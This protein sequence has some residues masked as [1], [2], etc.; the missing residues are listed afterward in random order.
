MALPVPNLDDRRFQDLVDEAK[1]LVQ[2]RCPEWTDHN[3]SDP[4]VTL[5]E[6][7]AW[8]TDQVVYRLNRVPDRNYV[9]FLELIGVSLYPPT[10]ARTS[11]TFWLSAPQP[12][13]VTIAAGTQAATVR[14]DTSEAIAFTSIEDLP[15]VPSSLERLGSMIDGKTLRD[16]SAALEKGTE[17][18]CFQPV[19]KA[20][21][22]L[23][24][25]LSEAVP[26]NAVRLRFRADIEG[27]GVDPTNPPLAWEAWTGDDWEPCELDSDTTGGLNRD[28][29]VVIHVP[30]GHVVSLIAKQRGGW[31][32]AR[33]TQPVEGQ[34][35]YS[36]SPNIKGLTAITIGGTV[37]AVNAELVYGEEVGISD[38]VPGQRFPVKRGPIVPGD[39]A[40]ILEVTGAEGWDEWTHVGDFAASGPDDRHFVL[41]LSSGEVRLGPAVRLADGA[42]RRYGAVPPK[43]AHLRLREYRVGG[44]RRGNVATR[45]ISVMKSSIPFVARVENRRPARGGVDGEDIENAKVRGPIRLRARGRAVTTEDYEQLAREA[46]PEVARV[47]AVAA[48]DGADAGAVRVLIVPSAVSEQGRLRFDQLVP[49]E[50]TLQ[51][52][53]DRLE[54]SRVIGTRAIIEPPVYRGITVVA[55]LKARNRVN[56]TRL[57]EEALAALY[58]YFNPITGGPDGTGWP[59]GRPVNV[60][61]VYSVL[62]GIRGTEL[63]EDARLFGA[64][65]VTGQRGTQTPRLELEAHALVFSYEHQVLVEGA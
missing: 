21:D 31:I 11:L 43:G 56:P 48:G 55:K 41:D 20:G 61:E 63:V 6:L 8:M 27:V 7:F 57:Q 22:A 46:A 62:Q 16:H 17:F 53:T 47:R 3:V 60:G 23:Y 4:G 18:A 15:I 65:P 9:K 58:E 51:K 30:R 50:D 13:T 2:Q 38:G 35:P 32:R 1:R 26:S 12:D 14:T 36:A 24:I 52:I 45:A 37:D 39:G 42:F 10:A 40:A 29:D 33:V 44:G 59:F 5:I 19:P 25:G 28:G 64:D 49:N 54:E 34:P